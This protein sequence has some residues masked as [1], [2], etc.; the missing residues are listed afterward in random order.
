VSKRIQSLAQPG[1]R[2]VRKQDQ[3][4]VKPGDYPT[5]ARYRPQTK[6]NVAAG[7]I[8]GGLLGALIVAVLEWM[9]AG[10]VRTPADVERKL[11]LP[12]LEAI[13]ASER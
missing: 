2:Q 7:G 10:L 11:G 9:E 13:P 3:V 8:L 6:I 1:K 5:F 4:D 12:V